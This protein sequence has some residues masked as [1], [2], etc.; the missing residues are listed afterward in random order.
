MYIAL[1]H[2]IRNSKD[3]TNADGSINIEL[4]ST[5]TEAVIS[6]S[7]KGRGMDENFVRE[8]LFKPFDS[9]KGAQGIGIGAYQIRET[10]EGAGGNVLVDSVPMRELH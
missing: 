2:A 4:T 7:D 10:I 5:D 8:R 1:Y 3:A 6:V 9:T